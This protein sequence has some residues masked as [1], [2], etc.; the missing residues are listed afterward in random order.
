MIDANKY[1]YE[2]QESKEVGWM[3]LPGRNEGGK[4]G[5]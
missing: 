4:H 1:T 3:I 5:T 2:K